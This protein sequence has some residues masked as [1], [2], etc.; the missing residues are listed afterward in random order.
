M[1]CGLLFCAG[2][3]GAL[4]ERHYGETSKSC[5]IPV[6][7]SLPL[8][9]VRQADAKPAQGGWYAR[10]GEEVLYIA[11]GGLQAMAPATGASRTPIPGLDSAA[12]YELAPGS[13]A[14][15]LLSAD[16]PAAFP[17]SALRLRAYSVPAFEPLWTVDH[18][19][20]APPFV[21]GLG[22][23]GSAIILAADNKL[24]AYDAANGGVLWRRDTRS[25]LGNV[26]ASAQGLVLSP[27]MAGL[28]AFSAADGSTAWEFALPGSPYNPQRYV[29]ISSS[30]VYL[31]LSESVLGAVDLKS[32]ALLWKS[33]PLQSPID[34]R[35][36]PIHAPEGIF[37][38]TR[39][40]V[41]K[42]ALDGAPLWER[43]YPFLAMRQ[44]L[45]ALLAASNVLL[46]GASDGL[47][48]LSPESGEI[49]WE[50]AGIGEVAD[51]DI[52]DGSVIAVN[53]L[54]RVH[55]FAH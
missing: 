24:L 40:G 34:P 33:A 49:S 23:S 22:L 52:V 55:V 51:I 13:A 47:V 12:Q 15:Y 30:T 44:G 35:H 46:I 43:E 1:L 36:P 11:D 18:E 37:V 38:L 48:A 6:E 26:L 5:A 14:I 42:L 27:T 20:E 3:G 16:A 2:A 9:L 45:P 32:G 19:S 54:G 39:R 4:A 8:R 25:F 29:S 53:L 7:I 50:H 31:P 41:A 21:R 10:V 17:Q 28:A